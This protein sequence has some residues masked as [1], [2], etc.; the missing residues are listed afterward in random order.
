MRALLLCGLAAFV[1]A[2]SLDLAAVDAAPPVFVTPSVAVVSQEAT[3]APSPTLSSSTVTDTTTTVS[4]PT[5]E[6]T[7]SRRSRIQRLARRDGDCSPQPQGS[8]PV[9][10]PDTPEA[11]QANKD[12][13]VCLLF[14]SPY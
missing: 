2:Q 8:G 10:S 11:F 13:Q 3:Y 5:D 14:C 7:V 12:L 4:T 9:T 1:S 6:S